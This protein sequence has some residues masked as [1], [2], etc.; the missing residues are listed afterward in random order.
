M[1][2]FGG[3][4]DKRLELFRYFFP[5]TKGLIWVIVTTA[6]YTV[7]EMV[8]TELGDPCQHSTSRQRWDLLRTRSGPCKGHTWAGK[9]EHHKGDCLVDEP[10]GTSG[11]KGG[12]K[13]GSGGGTKMFCDVYI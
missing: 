2:E 4:Y 6:S 1:K 7:L 5:S 10:P 11:T 9:E 13:K 12:G 3:R 8:M